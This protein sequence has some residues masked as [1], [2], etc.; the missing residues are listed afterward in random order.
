V[1]NRWGAQGWKTVHLAAL[2]VPELQGALELAW[3]HA[4]PRGRRTKK[5]ETTG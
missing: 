5:R 4:Q 1:P 2:G 3:R